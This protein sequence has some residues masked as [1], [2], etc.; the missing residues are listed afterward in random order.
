MKISL[1]PAPG[2]SQDA[3]KL[4]GRVKNNNGGDVYQLSTILIAKVSKD[5]ASDFM[6]IPYCFISNLNQWSKDDRKLSFVLKST[7]CTTY[8]TYCAAFQELSTHSSA[9]GDMF[10]WVYSVSQFHTCVWGGRMSRIWCPRKG[11]TYNCVWR[12]FVSVQSNISNFSL[13]IVNKYIR[14]HLM[15]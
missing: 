15:A 3:S 4:E 8:A 11:S 9:E 1:Y 2:L 12:S 13:I 6:N 7:I 14:V 5:R 10:I